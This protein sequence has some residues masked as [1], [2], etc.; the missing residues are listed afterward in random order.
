MNLKIK[1]TQKSKLRNN[2]IDAE[3]DFKLSEMMLEHIQGNLGV[4]NLIPN[5]LGLSQVQISKQVIDHNSLVLKE[6]KS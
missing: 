1:L 2:I 6:E 4:N 5:V 3:T